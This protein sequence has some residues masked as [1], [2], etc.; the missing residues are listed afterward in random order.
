MNKKEIDVLLVETIE[1]LHEKT[2]LMDQQ[3]DNIDERLQLLLQQNSMLFNL[4]ERLQNE[5]TLQDEE[6][7]K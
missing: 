4:L 6:T 3:I 1:T 7:R 5:K 2:L